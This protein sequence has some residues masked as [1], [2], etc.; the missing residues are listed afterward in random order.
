MNFEISS[1]VVTGHC[2]KN[3]KRLTSR[4]CLWAAVQPLVATRLQMFTRLFIETAGYVR[5]LRLRRPDEEEHP[6]NAFRAAVAWGPGA[7]GSTGF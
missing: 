1:Q 4:A 7:S 5:P 3:T 6:A 2:L